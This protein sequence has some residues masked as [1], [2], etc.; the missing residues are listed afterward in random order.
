MDP[1]A[2]PGG[3]WFFPNGLDLGIGLVS[4]ALAKKQNG[5]MVV[6]NYEL[7]DWEAQVTCTCLI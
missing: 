7:L 6:M 3:S 2:H 5:R 1:A 4:L